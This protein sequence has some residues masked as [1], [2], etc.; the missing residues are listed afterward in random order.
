MRAG[1]EYLEIGS[2]GCVSADKLSAIPFSLSAIIGSPVDNAV[3]KRS[4]ALH[5]NYSLRSSSFFS[6]GY[7]VA[8]QLLATSLFLALYLDNEPSL[9]ANRSE[10]GAGAAASIP[11]FSLLAST[12]GMFSD[13]QISGLQQQQQQQHTTL[14][15]TS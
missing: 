3:K 13:T 14:K 9:R 8:E 4:W 1:H 10:R 12:P 11:F 5:N 7:N 2:M 6:I 15:T